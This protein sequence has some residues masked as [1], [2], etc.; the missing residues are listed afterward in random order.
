M[1]SET[2]GRQPRRCVSNEGETVV[3]STR[4]ELGSEWDA[5][6]NFYAALSN[7]CMSYE[8]GHKASE[9]IRC[10]D[11]AKVHYGNLKMK[12]VDD[13]DNLR[14]S[15]NYLEIEIGLEVSE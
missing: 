13:V 1:N 6:G 15:L 7:A 4:G 8:W 10:I 9:V 14:K 2:R 11:S 5:R 3:G 12:E